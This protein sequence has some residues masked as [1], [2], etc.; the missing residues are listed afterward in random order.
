MPA[1]KVKNNI[2]FLIDPTE[3]LWVRGWTHYRLAGQTV[4]RMNPLTREVEIRDGKKWI[5]CVNGSHEFFTSKSK[6]DHSNRDD[7]LKA[8][9]WG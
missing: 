5:K 9:S 2:L 3:T 6:P 8:T 4:A 7:D 1:S